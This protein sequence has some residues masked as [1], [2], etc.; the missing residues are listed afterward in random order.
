MVLC[1]VPVQGISANSE[2][3][4]IFCRAADFRSGYSAQYSAVLSALAGGAKP[5]FGSVGGEWKV[6]ALA[7]SGYYSVQNSYF[8]EYYAQIEKLVAANGAPKLHPQKSTENSRLIIA[9][10]AIGRDA[11]D[12]SGFDLTEPL[13]DINYVRKQGLNGVIF[14]LIALDCNKAYGMSG[15]KDQCIDILLSRECD[16]GGWALGLGAA[17]ADITAMA[18]T[19]LAPHKKASAAVK[20]GVEKLSAL[21]N[22]NGSFSSGGVET[23]ESCS[24]VLVALSTVGIDAH[25]DARFIKNGNSALDAL[26][27][28][29]VNG[30]FAHMANGGKNSMAT[31]QA[32]YALCAYDRFVS[33]KSTLYGMSDVSPVSTAAPT[34]Q[35]TPKP[36]AK[37]TEQPAETPYAENTAGAETPSPTNSPSAEPTDSAEVVTTESA[38]PSASNELNDSPSPA[39]LSPAQTDVPTNETTRGSGNGGA[40]VLGCAAVCA[41]GIA[42]FFIIRKRKN[43]V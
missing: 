17:E 37:P 43:K 32:A 27:A 25:R 30:G 22:A 12:V 24:Q 3:G 7:R 5:E 1:A 38:A 21:Q 19:A 26:G 23:S 29:Y 41:V 6:L 20:R 4:A 2:C 31:E 39:T 15:I 35:P 16:G 10:S 13:S 14:A 40:V 28:F 8:S 34:E 36:S 9:L 33:G 18:I 11:R 42:V